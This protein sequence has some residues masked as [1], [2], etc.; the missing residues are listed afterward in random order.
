[1]ARNLLSQWASRP[2]LIVWAFAWVIAWPQFIGKPHRAQRWRAVGIGQ[3]WSV[4]WGD[5]YRVD[6][7]DQSTL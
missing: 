6:S 1:M 3:D 4:F 5:F 2:L 7:Y